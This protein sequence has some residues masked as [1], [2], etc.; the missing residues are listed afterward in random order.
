MT[1]L[2]RHGVPALQGLD[3]RALVRRLRE[4][5]ALRGVLTTERSDVDCSRR[6][7]GRLPRHGRPRPGGRGRP[8]PLRYEMPAEG[9]ERR[10]LAVYDFGVKTNILRSLTRRGARL[11]V[12]PARTPASEALALGVDGVVLSNGPGDP[13]PLSGIIEGVRELL[14]AEVPGLRHLPGA[15]APGAGR[16]ADAPSSSS[17]AIMAATNRCATCP[18]ARWPSPARTTAS[19]SIPIP[20]P[21]P[22]G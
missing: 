7:A 16:W 3:T 17:S 5:G 13:E 1:Y 12:L 4:R 18:P 19:P 8:A 14:A 10:H 11:T 6:R 20:C 21:P 2:R 9:E 22:A 15:P